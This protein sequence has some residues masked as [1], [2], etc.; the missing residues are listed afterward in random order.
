MKASTYVFAVLIIGWSGSVADGMFLP[1]SYAPVDRLISNMTAYI[2]ENPDTPHGYYVLGRVH[3]RAFVTKASVLTLWAHRELGTF[4]RQMVEREAIE[5]TLGE[6][7]YPS[8]ADIPE[9]DRPRFWDAVREKT[10]KLAQRDRPQEKD[11]KKKY[12]QKELA[13]H[14]ATAVRNFKKSIRLDPKNGLYYLGLASLL[15]Q[16]VQFLREI[17]Q[18]Y[19][20]E[21]LRGIF[22]DRAK[23][24]YHTAHS[25][26]IKNDL[27]LDHVPL[28]GLGSLVG[29]EAGQ[30]YI[31]L[32]EVQK[33]IPK[34]EQ[35]R[36]A[37]VKKDLEKLKGLGPGPITLII[38]IIWRIF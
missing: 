8:V 38:E 23:D 4:F 15:E 5:M 9:K 14:A 16:Y 17:K 7:G 26:S 27:K 24:V 3:Y 18:D 22:L 35:A 29:Y 12:N 6:L 20:P 10:E 21:E 32:A 1:P 37:R 2:K 13:A 25:L 34:D 30:A 31:R 19:V 11:L 28:Q 33:P 36:I